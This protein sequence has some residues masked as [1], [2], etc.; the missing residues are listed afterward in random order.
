MKDYE[1]PEGNVPVL[2]TDVIGS[3]DLMTSWGDEAA[4]E[5]LRDGETVI[6]EGAPAP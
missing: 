5:L 2:F 1:L 3:T 4:Q 6:A